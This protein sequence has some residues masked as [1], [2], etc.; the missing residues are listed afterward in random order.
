MRTGRVKDLAPRRFELRA[1]KALIGRGSVS[2]RVT[3][4]PERALAASPRADLYMNRRL[5][6]VGPDF[7]EMRGWGGL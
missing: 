5:H 7:V 1:V 4:N 3:R 6:G 2:G